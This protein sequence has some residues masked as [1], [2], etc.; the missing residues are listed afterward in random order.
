MFFKSDLWDSH[1][2]DAALIRC[3]PSLY[4]TITF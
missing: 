3:P 4:S 2:P 1:L